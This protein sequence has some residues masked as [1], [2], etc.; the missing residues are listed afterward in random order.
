MD[1]GGM[2]SQ[3]VLRTVDR[4]PSCSRRSSRT[5]SRQRAPQPGESR[6][7]MSLLERQLKAAQQAEADAEPAPPPAPSEDEATANGASGVADGLPGSNLPAVIPVAEAGKGPS[8]PR[9]V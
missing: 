2:Y 3:R 4:D 1:P 6:E 8:G 9:N 7:S 5:H